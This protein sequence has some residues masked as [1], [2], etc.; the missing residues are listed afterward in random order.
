MGLQSRDVGFIHI[1]TLFTVNLSYSSHL[2]E[3]GSSV[4]EC[5]TRNRESP[6]SNLF[7]KFGHFS[8]LHDALVHSAV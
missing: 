6:G 1:Q 2:V 7:S 3:H 4:V 8:S 5:R